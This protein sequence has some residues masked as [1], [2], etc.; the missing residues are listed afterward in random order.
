MLVNKF[1]NYFFFSFRSKSWLLPASDLLSVQNSSLPVNIDLV[2]T[3]TDL[4]L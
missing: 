1:T 4:N 2:R 3:V